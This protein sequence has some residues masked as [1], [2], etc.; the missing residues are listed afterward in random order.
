M[1]KQLQNAQ[2]KLLAWYDKFG[3][4]ELPWRNTEDVYHIYVSEIMLQQTQVKRVMEEYYP[5]FLEKFPTLKAL[6]DA[7]RR[8]FLPHGAG[9]GITLGLEIFMRL[10]NFPL[11]VCRRV[12]RSCKNFPVSGNTRRVR[13]AVLR[14]IKELELSILT[15]LGLSNGFLLFWMRLRNMCTKKRNLLCITCTR[16]PTTR[17]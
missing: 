1:S 11:L 14:T 6:G 5:Q 17:L 2:N 12:C 16:L 9:L 10:R 3:R 15:L 4:K 8:K 7:K 13:F